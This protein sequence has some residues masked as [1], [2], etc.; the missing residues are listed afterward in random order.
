M[1]HYGSHF[2]VIVK[3]Y[4]LTTILT[5]PQLKSP[6]RAV[7]HH[8]DLP[9]PQASH[10]GSCCCAGR[11]PGPSLPCSGR[12]G[13]Q[14]QL[15]FPVTDVF[16]AQ[17]SPVTPLRLQGCVLGFSFQLQAPFCAHCAREKRRELSGV[18]VMIPSALFMIS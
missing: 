13:T 2:L 18:L 15:V 1:T 3:D 5:I 8:P 4:A 17:Q 12:L 14:Q 11:V 10:M 6:A 7:L 9:P 16:A